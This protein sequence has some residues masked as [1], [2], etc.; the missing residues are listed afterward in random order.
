MVGE[1]NRT[2]GRDQ[3]EHATTMCTDVAI[4]ELRGQL[5]LQPEVSNNGWHMQQSTTTIVRRRIHPVHTSV[6]AVLR[7]WTQCT[8]QLVHT[9]LCVCTPRRFT[10]RN[11]AP[12]REITRFLLSSVGEQQ[13]DNSAIMMQ[14]GQFIGHDMARTTQLNNAECQSCN[15]QS[16]NC[17]NLQVTPNDQRCVNTHSARTRHACTADLAH[18]RVCRWRAARPCAGRHRTYE[19]NSTRIPPLS[20]ARKC[21]AVHSMT[22]LDSDRAT[23][24]SC[25]L[26]FW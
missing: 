7:G 18:K 4:G 23:R 5:V 12:P 25:R 14:W 21:T 2:T 15:F 13:T 24:V 16:F 22:C 6:T 10:V 26:V 19:N 11:R 20:T 17:A 3:L 1:H 9:L 8:I